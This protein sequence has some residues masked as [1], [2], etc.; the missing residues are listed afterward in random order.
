MVNK[1]KDIY[2]TL[3]YIGY[4]KL[5]IYFCNNFFLSISVN[6]RKRKVVMV[7]KWKDSY[8]TLGSIGTTLGLLCF[9]FFKSH[10]RVLCVPFLLLYH[11]QSRNLCPNSS[12]NSVLISQDHYHLTQSTEQSPWNREEWLC[13]NFISETQEQCRNGQHWRLWNEGNLHHCLT[14]WTVLQ[15]CASPWLCRLSS[16]KCHPQ[17][18]PLFCDS[19][20]SALAAP[21]HTLSVSLPQEVPCDSSALSPLFPRPSMLLAPTANQCQIHYE[22]NL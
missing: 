15:S 5:F 10:G 2:L 8:L 20:L 16:Q 13:L 7:N 18:T 3:G 1:W 19:H 14:A 17:A 4:N 22:T 21:A 9:L 11:N 6:I 12:T